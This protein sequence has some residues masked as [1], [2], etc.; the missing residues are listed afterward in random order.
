MRGSLRQRSEGSWELRVHVGTDPETGRRVDR[1]VT[2]R[3]NRAEAERELASMVTAVQATRAIGV[4]ST[5]SELLEAWFAVARAG[6]A[7]TTIRQ[8]RSVLDRYLHP[9]LGE[10]CVGEVTPVMIDHAYAR[11][12]RAGGKSGQPLAPGTLA[13]IHVV[14][15]SAFSQAMRWGWVW[16]NPAERTHRIT[17]T[18]TEPR[19]PTPDELC[20]LLDHVAARDPQLHTF[21][22]LAT[23]TGAR[24]AQLLGLRWH[25]VDI[26]GRRVSF[27]NGWVEG[28]EGPVL[29]STKTRRRHIVD[30]DPGSFAIL[31]THAQRAA[32]SWDGFAF[33]DDGGR[34]AWKPNRVTK[35]FLRHRRAAGLRPFRLHDLRHFMATQM[36]HAGIPLITVSRRLDHRRVSTILD[37]YAHAI[38]GGDAHAS[39]TLWH[40][41]ETPADTR[42]LYT[43]GQPAAAPAWPDRSVPTFE[44]A[45]P[46]RRETHSSLR[47]A[48][49]VATTDPD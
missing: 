25:N 9:Q 20:A 13:R 35:T 11:L 14:L 27:C 15:R 23:V 29:T 6:W 41:L 22:V 18:T 38:P 40:L 36:L 37:H 42:G 7:P 5:V 4:R 17:A 34:T 24:R 3:G 19:P 30:L 8:T 12:H 10:V 16:D 28:P 49:P 47:R 33:S 44:P 31:A 32:S 26:V 43:T 21:L 45:L 39:A 48:S 46:V 2:I 1:S